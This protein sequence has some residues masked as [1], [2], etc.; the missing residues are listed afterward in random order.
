L[1]A[2]KNKLDAVVSRARALVKQGVPKSELLAKLATDD[3]GWR[4]N[5]TP[6]QLDHFYAEISQEKDANP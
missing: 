4:L 2:Y 6:D 5:L 1:E 3:L